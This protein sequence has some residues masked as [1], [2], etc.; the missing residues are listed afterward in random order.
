MNR[1]QNTAAPVDN[2]LLKLK[3]KMSEQEKEKLRSLMSEIAKLEIQLQRK[4]L[5]RQEFVLHL[6]ENHGIY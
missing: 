6:Q 4:V 1:P 3:D 5:D 2:V